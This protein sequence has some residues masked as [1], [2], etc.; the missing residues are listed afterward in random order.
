M[1]APLTRGPPSR[2]GRRGWRGR[3][4]RRPRVAGRADAAADRGGAGHVHRRAGRR[5][6]GGGHRAAQ[7]LAPAAGARGP[8]RRDHAQQHHH[9]RAHGGGEDRD[10]PASRAP[11]GRSVREGRSVEVHRGRLRRDGT[12]SPSSAT[13][14]TWPSTWSGTSGRRRSRSRRRKALRSG[15]STCCSRRSRKAPPAPLRWRRAPA[16]AFAPSSSAPAAPRR[17]AV[18]RCGG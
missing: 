4:W 10:R 14:W 13:S 18:L 12:W 15:S 7:P 16:R 8:A 5:Q 6:E 9:D 11:G 3:R 17:S 2:G 1:R